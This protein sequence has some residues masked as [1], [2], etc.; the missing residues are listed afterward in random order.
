MLTGILSDYNIYLHVASNIPLDHQFLDGAHTNMQYHLDQLSEWSDR[1]LTKLNPSKCSYMI[2]SRAK[3]D[4]VTRLSVGGVKIDQKGVTK[5]DG[6]DEEDKEG[7]GRGQGEG[8]GCQAQG[9]GGGI[10]H[11]PTL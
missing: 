3:V 5:M 11:L 6:G 7:G 9:G 1:N 4:F 10:I 8:G 2:L